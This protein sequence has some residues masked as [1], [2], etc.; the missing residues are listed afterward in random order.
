MGYGPNKY[1]GKQFL[2]AITEHIHGQL[3][4]QGE[5][6]NNSLGY[7]GARL[8]YK[9]EVDLLARGENQLIVTGE[10]GIIPT[11]ADGTPDPESVETAMTAQEGDVRETVIVEG[12]ST[13]G[14]ATHTQEGD[15]KQAG[16]QDGDRLRQRENVKG[17]EKEVV[18]KGAGTK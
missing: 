8:R 6:Q 14:T 17:K 7:F 3:L 1:T 18:G 15:R 13:M 9:V 5:F 4:K 2:A 10:T 11:L 12:G 16:R